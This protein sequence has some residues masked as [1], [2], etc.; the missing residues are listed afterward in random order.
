MINRGRCYVTRVSFVQYHLSNID[1]K[2]RRSGHVKKLWTSV[3]ITQFRFVKQN[4]YKLTRYFNLNQLI[5]VASIVCMSESQARP[6]FSG[7][8]M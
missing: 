7:D 8:M 5:I 2:V 1:K 4:F 6:R 3:Y